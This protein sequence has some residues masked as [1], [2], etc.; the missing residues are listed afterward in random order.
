MRHAE[1][2]EPDGELSIRPL[3][4]A[5]AT[6][7]YT[8]RGDAEEEWEP[9]FTFHGFRYAEVDGYPGEL[10]TQDIRA[11]VCHTDME[12]A[13]W[14]SCSEPLLN[15][16]HDNAVWSMRGNFLDI[17][18]DCPQRDE[19]LGW[20]GDAQIFAPAATFLYECAGLLTSWLRDLAAEQTPEGY[21]PPF[22]PYVGLPRELRELE[23]RPMAFAAWGDAV[24]VVPWVI[25]QRLADI[26]VLR[27]QYPGMKAWVD[28]VADLA[29]EN[30]VWDHGF[31]FGD[32]VDPSAPPDKPWAAKTDPHLVATAYL[33][34]SAELLAETA[35]VLGEAH[36]SARYRELAERVRAAFERE[37]AS[38]S[39]R[40]VSDAQT[41]YALALRFHLV[42]GAE[43][44]ERAGRRL[45]ELVAMGGDRIGT[46]FVGT[47][48]ICDALCDVS[49]HDTAYRLLLQ[50]E[51]PS[52]L[53]PV[54]M[55]A[56]TIWERWDSMLPDGS[57]NP[58]EM[59]SFNHYALGA[60]VDWLHRAVAGLAP[61]G[62]G[63]RR[64][65]V[66]PTPG[67]GLRHAHAAHETPY[68]RAEAGWRRENG[69]LEVTVL[70]PPNVTARI[71]LPRDGGGRAEPVEVGS[72]RH[73]FSARF[74]APEADDGHVGSS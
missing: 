70:V 65:L 3:R 42:R 69:K 64:L 39:G 49:E 67:G 52:W 53:Y 1:V 48:L 12:R 36:D 60:V 37:Y 8:L 18:T 27:R 46:G 31:Q 10:R 14:F 45:A 47:P 72:G 16:L 32:W 17:P 33:A 44:R 29:G 57:V 38:P 4:T 50:R 7:E 63:Y 24:V 59:T 9:R 43:R 13:G 25:Y 19:R 5:S 51:C 2:L 40:L 23:R 68:G 58:G 74:R 34:R 30:H 21:V 61:D 11:V 55:G 15:R 20:T 66:R 62:P 6:D 26:D 41:A 56:T 73:M 35:T 22:V 71:E 54:T 28:A